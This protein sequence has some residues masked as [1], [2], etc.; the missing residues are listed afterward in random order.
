MNIF[1]WLTSAV[2]RCGIEFAFTTISRGGGNGQIVFTVNVKDNQPLS[3]S[4]EAVISAI[5]LDRKH[6]TPE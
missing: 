1:G 5:R 4:I 3:G 2:V 6:F